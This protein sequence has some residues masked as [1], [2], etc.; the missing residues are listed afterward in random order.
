MR[1]RGRLVE[2]LMN[3]LTNLQVFSLLIAGGLRHFQPV[4]EIVP[5]TWG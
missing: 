3:P 5:L 1:L 2:T 4:F